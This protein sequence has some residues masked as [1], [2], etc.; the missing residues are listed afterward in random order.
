MHD[1]LI[2]HSKIDKDYAFEITD[3]L[4]KSGMTVWIAPRNIQ[5]GH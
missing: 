3:N 1:I 2:S 4:E 5:S